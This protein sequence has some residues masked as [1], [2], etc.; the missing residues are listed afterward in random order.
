[1]LARA[2]S[3]CRDSL[4]T[5][6]NNKYEGACPDGF[7]LLLFAY[8]YQFSRPKGNILTATFKNFFVLLNT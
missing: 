1:L 6:L 4:L 5:A 8:H 7:R 2:L 3:L